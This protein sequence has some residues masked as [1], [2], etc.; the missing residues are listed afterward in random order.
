MDQLEFQHFCVVCLHSVFLLPWPC[1][2][3]NQWCTQSLQMSAIFI[4]HESKPSHPICSLPT[5]TLQHTNSLHH[6]SRQSVEHPHV[7]G[8]LYFQETAWWMWPA[9]ILF[10]SQSLQSASGWNVAHVSTRLSYFHSCST[11]ASQAYQLSSFY[12]QYHW[13]TACQVFVCPSSTLDC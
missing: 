10:F 3:P 1:A 8:L 11:A 5:Q 9:T 2:S 13:S 12:Q 6:S 7:I 4:F